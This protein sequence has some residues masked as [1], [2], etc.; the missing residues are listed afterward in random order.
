M[1]AAMD[2]KRRRRL[3][4]A[5]IE[6]YERSQRE[7]PWRRT[8]DPYAIWVS[9]VMLQQTRVE[10][11][12]PYFLRWMERFPSVQALAA[13]PL[14]DVL[15]CWSGLGYYTRARNLHRAAQEVA[16]R[17]GGD[18]PD[19][20]G[21]L[22]ELPGIGR[23]TAGAIASIAFGR[24]EPVV[25]GNVERVLARLLL[26]KDRD[27]A[28][29]IAA[30]LV[31]AG[32]A[33]SFNQALMELGAT[34]CIPRRPLCL[35]CPVRADCQARALGI[36]E[37][38]P[39]RRV[40]RAVPVVDAAVAV[41]R[42]GV[43]LLLVRRPPSG[44]WGGLWEFPTAELGSGE[45]PLEAARRACAAVGLRAPF[46]DPVALIE[47]TLTHRHMR[48]HCFFADAQPGRARLSGYDAHRWL[49]RPEVPAAP[50][51]AATRR[52]PSRIDA[53]WDTARR[54]SAGA[55]TKYTAAATPKPTNQA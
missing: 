17:H 9:E 53:A 41:V 3:R 8:R 46:G 30:R 18:L 33:A 16:S 45:T 54:R 51:S 24:S 23:Y 20:A 4:A 10:T 42:R 36:H 19:D 48:F 6:W 11:V 21:R 39:P 31:P 43:R 47:H 26:A 25:D 55:S 27:E 7:L 52:S 34:V 32:D 1:R 12:V 28:W 49:L 37:H 15:G 50:V 13:A 38:V 44:L 29:E 22:R 35:V 2:E 40:A 5:L 14:D